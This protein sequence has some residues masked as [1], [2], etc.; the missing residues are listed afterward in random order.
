LTVSGRSRHVFSRL[1]DRG[2]REEEAMPSRTSMGRRALLSASLG[3]LA[4][5]AVAQQDYPNRPLRLVVPFAPGGLTDIPARLLAAHMSR[6]LGQAVAVENRPGAAGTIGAELVRGAPADGYTLL[7]ANAASN[8]QAPALRRN[9]TY[10]P[11]ENFA[12]VVLAVISPFALVVRADRPLRSMADLV[13]LARHQGRVTFGTTGPGGTGHI[14]ALMLTQATGVTF[15]PIHFAGDAPA[16]QEVLAGRLDTHYAAAARP[17]VEAGRLFP[18]A[19]TGAERWS[20]FPEAPT[21]VELGFKGMDL[22]GWNGIAAPRA[23][24]PEILAKLNAAANLALAD[25]EVRQRL[26]TAGLEPQGGTSARF[27]VHVAN[28]FARYRRIAQEFNL[29]MD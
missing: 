24:V 23:T 16:I 7:Q 5:R 3:A 28:E 11:V 2:G 6:T 15:E 10:N 12:P 21:L 20:I 14:L 26:A 25:A 27:G 8:A 9:V 1:P 18:V 29:F 4:G 19:T 22:Y 13:A 17:H